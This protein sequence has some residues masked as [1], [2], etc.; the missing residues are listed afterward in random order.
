MANYKSLQRVASKS[1]A[2]NVGE[3]VRE[4]T[5]TLSRLHS[6]LSTQ[7]S[8]DF[9]PSKTRLMQILANNATGATAQQ[10]QDVNDLLEGYIT[11]DRKI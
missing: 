1:S 11:N 5:K 10:L 9:T 4:L 7:L 8:Q 2:A 3:R 6:L